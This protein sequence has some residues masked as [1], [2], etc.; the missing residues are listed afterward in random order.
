MMDTDNFMDYYIVNIFYN[1]ID[2]PGHNLKYFRYSGEPVARPPFG[3]D[4]RWRWAFNDFDFGFGNTSGLYPHNQN[5]LAYATH[6]EGGSWP[7]NPPWSTFLI[8]NLLENDEFRNGF[9]NRFADLLNSIFRP[10]YMTG[11]INEMMQVI[12]PEME[13]HMRRWSHPATGMEDWQTNID[14]MIRF[15]SRRPDHQTGHILGYF[16]LD[17]TYMLSIDVND[18]G[19]GTVRVNRLLL[20]DTEAVRGNSGEVFP[21]TGTYFRN[22]PLPLTAV[23]FPGYEFARWTNSSGEEF[24]EN[25]HI[26]DASDDFELTAE[27]RE[28]KVLPPDAFSVGDGKPFLFT[29]WDRDAEAG[30]HPDHMAFVYMDSFDP[31]LEAMIEGFTL[32]RYDLES[33]TRITGWDCGGISFVNTSSIEGNPGYPGGRLGGLLLALNTSDAGDLHLMFHSATVYRNSRIYNIRLQY[34]LDDHGPFTDLLNQ[35][36]QPVEYRPG[37]DGHSWNSGPVPLPGNLHGQDYVQLL[38]RYYYSGAREDAGNGQRSELRIGSISVFEGKS[39]PFNDLLAS[40]AIDAPAGTICDNDTVMIRALFMD[41]TAGTV[42]RWFIGDD[43]LAGITGSTLRLEAPYPG[44]VLHVEVDDQ[45][46]CLFGLPAISGKSFAEII[47]APEK[48][49]IEQIGNSL[50]S[51]SVSGNQWYELTGG[52]IPGADQ[53][54]FTPEANGSYYVIVSD[55]QCYSPPS[56]LVAFGSAIIYPA[57]G[58]PGNGITILPNPAGNTIRVKPG[59]TDAEFSQWR[60]YDLPGKVRLLGTVDKLDAGGEFLLDISSLDPGVYILRLIPGGESWH[61]RKEING[62]FIKQ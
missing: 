16:G 58:Q 51:S 35:S 57:D 52:A 40:A 13:R 21:W 33:R 49:L 9:I 25:P 27:F 62:I 18:P 55:G 5:T 7:P 1:N 20:E 23:A 39:F 15:A 24:F 3:M 4:G 44:I 12:E 29:R 45:N 11:F 53:Q 22:T 59:A 46:S 6:P 56:G 31:G 32:G 17:G 47:P 41:E 30:I 48:P 26:V 37:N 43:P 38:W 10:E 61:R 50:Y 34:R 28:R 19:A 60:I 42:Y 2:W 8:R 54:E 14:R 36:G